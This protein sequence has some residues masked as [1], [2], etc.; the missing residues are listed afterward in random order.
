MESPTPSPLPWKLR[1]FNLVT[2]RR[3]L[4]DANGESV[5]ALD[6]RVVPVS[7]ADA[8]FIVRAVNA[9]S[10]LVEALKKAVTCYC[11]DDLPYAEM[12]AALALA[13]ER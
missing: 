10:A 11:I 1:A 13:G 2:L 4:S 8:D 3:L 6:Y 7:D 12:R 9:H 5:A